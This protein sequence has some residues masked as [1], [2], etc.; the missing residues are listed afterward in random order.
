MNDGC[1]MAGWRPRADTGA[2]VGGQLKGL[3]GRDYYDWRSGKR[4]F[5]DEFDYFV[6]ARQ[7]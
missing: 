5:M 3:S 7:R 2:A 4:W 6:H 1:G